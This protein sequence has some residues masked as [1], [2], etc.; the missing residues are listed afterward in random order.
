MQPIA[1]MTAAHLVAVPA[2]AAH[3]R[4]RRH[5]PSHVSRAGLQL[6]VKEAL[7]AAAVQR[8]DVQLAAGGSRQQP[9]GGGRRL[10]LQAA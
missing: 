8:G 10:V 9:R 2:A 3:Q 6:L 7:H 1:L 5:E 4:Q